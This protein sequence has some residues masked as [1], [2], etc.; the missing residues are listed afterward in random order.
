MPKYKNYFNN[1]KKNTFVLKLVLAFFV[2]IFCSSGWFFVSHNYY[3]V[4]GESMLPTISSSG[5]GAFVSLFSDYTYGD[6]VVAYNPDNI[7]I[8]KRVIGLEG[9]KVGFIYN[10][11][12]NLYELAIIY[13][14]TNEVKFVDEPYIKDKSI[15]N[16]C[17]N[18][19]YTKKLDKKTFE[20]IIVNGKEEK[21]LVVPDGFV[22]LLGDNRLVSL[23]CAT[24]GAIKTKYVFGKVDLVSSTGLD[25]FNVILYTFNLRGTV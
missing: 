4:E 19:L 2:G 22:F 16:Y 9:D 18:D 12:N 3:P 10:E 11:T 14:G 6:I 25:I 1:K 20:K 23:D 24:H 17:A 15:N 5:S 13:A 7:R 21:F 8:L